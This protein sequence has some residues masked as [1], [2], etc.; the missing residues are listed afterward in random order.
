MVNSTEVQSAVSRYVSALLRDHF[1]KGPTSAFATLSSG[2]I[3]IHLRGFLSP[4]EK[5]LLKQERHKLIL[6]MRDILLEELKPEIRFQLLKSANFE[7]SYIFADS[8]LD[9]QTCLIMAEV[10]DLPEGDDGPW[11]TGVDKEAFRQ[12]IIDMSEKS[13]KAPE[14]TELYWLSDRTILVKRVGILVEIE[15]ALVANGYT[16]ELKVT[17][18]PLEQGLLDKPKIEGILQRQ[19]D[20]IF[21]DWDF[22]QDVGYIVFTLE[23]Q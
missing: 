10:K 23:K 15:K 1:G 9:Q 19:I 5:I 2:F 3:T 6:E 7:A 22:D 18:R 21:L 4:T 16:E 17:K 12:E 11:P 20:E 8:D 13:E 14:R